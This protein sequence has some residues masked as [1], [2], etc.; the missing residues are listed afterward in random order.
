MFE[1]QYVDHS[2][3]PGFTPVFC[4]DPWCLSFIKFF[5][6]LYFLVFLFFVCLFVCCFCWYSWSCLHC[7][8]CFWFIHVC[9]LFLLVLVVLFPLL[10]VS[11]VYSFLFSLSIVYLSKTCV[12]IVPIIMEYTCIY[13]SVIFLEYPNIY[14]LTLRRVW[15]YQRGNQN[16]YIE[17]EQT[18]QW[19]KENIRYLKYHNIYTE[20]LT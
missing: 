11:L 2:K 18:T 9:L 4:W 7:C 15:R 8:L 17:E 16:P 14:N 12:K 3:T 13:T 5:F 20:M 10:L 1:C 6:V 19:P